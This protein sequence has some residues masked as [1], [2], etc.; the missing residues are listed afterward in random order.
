MDIKIYDLICDCRMSLASL[1]RAYLTNSHCLRVKIVLLHYGSSAGDRVLFEGVMSFASP[2]PK[3]V[4]YS[5]HK[6][7]S[8][9]NCFDEQI[10][11]YID[12]PLYL[13]Y[14]GVEL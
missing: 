14:M 11:I 3:I 13:D 7:V 2:V 5:L 10:N 4:Y 1:L 9:F 6:T 8:F 12:D